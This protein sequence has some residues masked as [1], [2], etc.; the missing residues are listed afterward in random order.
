MVISSPVNVQEIRNYFSDVPLFVIPD[1][2]WPVTI[3]YTRKPEDDYFKAAI[4]TVLQIH[5]NEPAGDILLFLTSEEEIEDACHILSSEADHLMKG[6][7][8]GPMKVYPLR[9]FP[10]NAFQEQIAYPALSALYPAAN[11]GRKVILVRNVVA[12]PKIDGVVYVVDPGFSIQHVYNPRIRMD[13]HLISPI[14]KVCARERSAQASRSRSGKCFR[15]YTENACNQEL[16]KQPYPEILRTNC[17]SLVLSLKELGVQSLLKFEFLDNPAPESMMRALEELNYLGG[18]DD[19][20]E[21]TELGK[22]V[23]QIP[24]DPQ[25]A[26]M[27]VS[28]P[29][30][31]CSEEIVSLTALLSVPDVFVTNNAPQAEEVKKRFAYPESDHLTLLNVYNAFKAGIHPFTSKVHSVVEMDPQ[32]C[33]DHYLSHRSLSSADKM[34]GQLRRILESN[35]V[36]IISTPFGDPA[37]YINIC[38]ALACGFFMQVAKKHGGKRSA[39]YETVND[40]QLVALHPSTVVVDNPEWVI[41]NEY[42]TT[43][44]ILMLT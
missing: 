24:V 11:A 1:T 34:R 29:K 10:L 19:D 4:Q 16:N 21:L 36:E 13:T 17:R 20:G 9:V 44:V 12:V 15:L 37:Y 23:A 31:Q 14:S 8:F 2:T 41:Y 22:L 32:W 33:H 6:A 35:D 27:L 39:T 25:L 5:Q 30:Y 7:H 28:S 43:F 38:R 26:I 18:L 3:N 42:P 40:Q